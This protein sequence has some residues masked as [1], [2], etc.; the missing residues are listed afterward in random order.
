MHRE[1]GAIGEAEK[2]DGKMR[3]L[4]KVIKDAEG[5]FPEYMPE[6]GKVY[7]AKYVPRSRRHNGTGNGEFCVINILDK[8]IVLRSGEYELVEEG[9]NDA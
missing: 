5:V 8:K 1:G 7:E 6:V 3:C 2:G 9:G 4:I